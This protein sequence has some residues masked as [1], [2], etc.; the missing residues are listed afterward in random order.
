MSLTSK[1]M[2][3]VA[4]LILFLLLTGVVLL[5]AH[6]QTFTDLHSL[7]AQFGK[8]LPETTQR[9]TSSVRSQEAL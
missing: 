1:R 2:L 5:P 6:A 3:I 8:K 9:T 4:A 7:G